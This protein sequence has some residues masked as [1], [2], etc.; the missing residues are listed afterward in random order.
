MIFEFEDPP[1]WPSGH[2]FYS[3]IK[4]TATRINNNLQIT[5]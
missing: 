2:F 3:T 4:T 5:S 1:R